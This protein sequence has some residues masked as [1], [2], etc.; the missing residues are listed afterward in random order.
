MAEIEGF[1]IGGIR[2]LISLVKDLA[3]LS[4][5]HSPQANRLAPSITTL[6]GAPEITLPQTSQLTS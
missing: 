3:E 2:D 1:P 6:K 5:E 4:L